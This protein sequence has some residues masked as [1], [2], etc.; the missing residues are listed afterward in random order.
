MGLIEG[1]IFF[2]LCKFF[3]W[4]FSNVLK[5]DNY[6]LTLQQQQMKEYTN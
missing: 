2:G 6:F 4:L 5:Q 3:T 1:Q